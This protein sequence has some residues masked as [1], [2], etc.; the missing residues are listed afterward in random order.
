MKRILIVG[1]VLG[2]LGLPLAASG[3][4]VQLGDADPVLPSSKCPGDP[5]LAVY[6]VTGYQESA[7]N[8]R[9]RP[10][11]VRRNGKILAFTVKLGRLTREQIETFDGL[12][13]GQASVRL[14]IVSRGRQRGRRNEHRV[15]ARSEVFEVQDYFGS[16]PTFVLEEPLEVKRGN[17][18]A[19]TVPTWAP[20]L[21]G[22]QQESTVWR[23]SR[24]RG[25]CGRDGPPARLAP[26]APQ[27]IGRP[28]KWACNYKG[29][30]LLYTA[31]YVPNNRRTRG[32]G[33]DTNQDGDRRRR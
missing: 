27:G 21:A 20:A 32:G 7:E 23:S 11:V 25:R 4:V 22:D 16:S 18:V 13:K 30:R 28:A 1:S 10:Y 8:S 5:C 9:E 26:P 33:D 6:Q 3:K 15:L 24:R 2:A 29:A 31:L 19:L 17:I 14:S 12:F